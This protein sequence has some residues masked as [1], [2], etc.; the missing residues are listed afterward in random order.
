VHS[1]HKDTSK[2]LHVNQCK[3]CKLNTVL[4]LR[5]TAGHCENNPFNSV[6]HAPTMHRFTGAIFL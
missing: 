3:A 6:P 4:I 5:L 1:V 2:R